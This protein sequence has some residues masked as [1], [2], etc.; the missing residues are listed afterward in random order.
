MRGKSVATNDRDGDARRS[1]RGTRRAA[2]LGR[3]FFVA[4]GAS[5]AAAAALSAAPAGASVVLTGAPSSVLRVAA[6]G[7]MPQPSALYA[8]H[9]SAEC[10]AV[11]ALGCT[12]AQ[13]EVTL[14]PT[15]LDLP[16]AR[17]VTG[18]GDGAPLMSF[19]LFHEL[20]HVFDREWMTDA[21]RARFMTILGRTDGW[22]SM[23]D[24]PPPAELFADA[25]ALCSIYGATIPRNLAHPV[26]Y[27][28]KPTVAVDAATCGIMVGV[29]GDRAAVALSAAPT[30]D[31]LADVLVAPAV[32]AGRVPGTLPVAD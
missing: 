1:R 20:G 11:G 7:R 28:W 9:W 18:L 26:G 5:V 4:L 30:G 32:P 21:D 31:D 13:G 12:L 25:Y 27:G 19:V 8:F 16:S 23:Q 10:G 22:W 3:T 14:D 15:L 6:S 2:A 29:A 24:G 17:V